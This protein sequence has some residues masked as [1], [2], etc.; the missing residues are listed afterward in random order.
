MNQMTAILIMVGMFVMF[1]IVAPTV[2]FIGAT[3]YRQFK[4]MKNRTE[5]Q[6]K[7]VRKELITAR[8]VYNAALRDS[9][10]DHYRITYT[11]EDGKGN[12]VEKCFDIARFPYQEGDRI[13]VYYDAENP[14]D[15]VT[16]DQVNM[17]KESPQKAIFVLLMIMLLGAALLVALV[18]IGVS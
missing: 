7:V 9:G 8:A 18:N 15:C 4:R 1:A 10:A 11:F 6:G 17:S 5:A 13:A 14:N 2:M 3:H 16:D 12:P